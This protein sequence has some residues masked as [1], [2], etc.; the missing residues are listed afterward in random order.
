MHKVD[1]SETGKTPSFAYQQKLCNKIV[2]F[3]WRGKHS[4]FVGCLPREHLKG[5]CLECCLCAGTQVFLHNF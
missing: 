2:C 1:V 4:P 3:D 5:I